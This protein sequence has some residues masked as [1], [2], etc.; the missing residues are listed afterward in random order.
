MKLELTWEAISAISNFVMAFGVFLA[1]AQLRMTQ[2]LS[3][4]NFED[5]FSKEYRELCTQF[6]AEV[7]LGKEITDAEYKTLFDE[8]YRYFDL[9][10][11]QII[12][13]QRNRIGKIVW[14]EW[15]SGIQ[16]NMSTPAFQRAWGELRSQIKVF[17]EL[18]HLIKNNYN[19]DPKYTQKTAKCKNNNQ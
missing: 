9:S 1:Y 19:I 10:N 4:L 3:Q 11:Q 6:P 13:R 15:C 2:R 12:L 8:F 7:L 16:S 18:E 5:Q 14:D 17:N